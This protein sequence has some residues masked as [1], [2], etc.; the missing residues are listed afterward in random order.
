[1]DADSVRELAGEF[2]SEPGVYQFVDDTRIIYIGKAVDIQSRVRSYADPRSYRI[3]QM[4]ESAV[5]IDIAVTD[6]ETQALLLEANLIKR[7]QPRFNVRLTDDKSYPLVQITNHEFPRIEVTREPSE[8]ALVWGPF[9][10]KGRVDTVVKAIRETYGLR[11]CSDHKFANRDRPCLDYDIGLCS[12]PCTSEITEASYHADVEMVKQFFD[13]AKGILS[14]SLRASMEDA[15]ADEEFERAANIRDR[16]EA[17]E[18]FNE[19]GADAIRSADEYRTREILGAVVAGEDAIVG[20]LHTEGGK[21]IDR[22]QHVL[23]TPGYTTTATVLAAFIPQFYAEREFPDALILSDHPADDEVLSW[24]EQEG[25][26]VSVPGG[27][28]EARLV[29]LALKNANRRQTGDA[30]V[31]L[32]EELGIP[33]ADRIEGFDVSH[34]GGKSTVG[35][36]VV[37]ENGVPDKSGYRRKRLLDQNDDTAA[38]EELIRW[39]VARGVEGRDDRRDPDLLVIDGGKG[40]LAVAREVIDEYEWDVPVVS[41]AKA[42]EIVYTPQ[43]TFNWSRDAAHLHL[44]QRV[45]DEAHRFARQYHQ[46]VRDE[47]TTIIDDVPGV[48]PVLRNRLLRRFGSVDGIK[49][50]SVAEL[51][52]IEGV[53]DETAATLSTHL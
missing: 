28:R 41:L 3:Q 18:A 36:N 32:A 26:A 24:L 30:G 21:L 5:D 45:R 49:S 29:D 17:V 33:Q 50:A 39:R 13:G 14:D 40:Q 12:A 31:A 4:V 22:E 1:M 16:L 52:E 48:G 6:T 37:F 43:D 44:L 42:E 9:T 51:R 35:S 47:I 19:G 53:G 7:H 46:L 2:P 25:V 27:G 38:M 15:A 34:A 20:R 11:G 8:E 10:D 23:E